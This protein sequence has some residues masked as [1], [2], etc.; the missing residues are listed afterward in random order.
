MQSGTQDVTR[1]V[2]ETLPEQGEPTPVIFM[3]R[4]PGINAVDIRPAFP[5][6][7]GWRLAIA[8]LLLAPGGASMAFGFGAWRQQ[9]KND[10]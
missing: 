5:D 3:T 9:I 8:L 2:F 1:S 7:T 4:N 10:T 6:V